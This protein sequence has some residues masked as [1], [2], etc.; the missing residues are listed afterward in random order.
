MGLR[1]ER[2][3]LHSLQDIC[4]YGANYVQG[5]E[6]D[7]RRHVEHAHRRDGSSDG[8]EYGLGHSMEHRDQFVF[9]AHVE[10]RQ[11]DPHE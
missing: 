1:I 6:D 7:K 2:D 3:S 9:G 11:D 4:E 5:D 8:F 10:P